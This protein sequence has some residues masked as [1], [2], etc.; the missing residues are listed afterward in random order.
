[1]FKTRLKG[2]GSPGFALEEKKKRMTIN[3]FIDSWFRDTQLFLSMFLIL[4]DRKSA[5]GYDCGS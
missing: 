4:I 2:Q 3:N 5:G 1:M